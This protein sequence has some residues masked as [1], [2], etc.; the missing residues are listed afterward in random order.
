MKQ[1]TLIGIKLAQ[2]EIIGAYNLHNK[3]ARAQAEARKEG[4]TFISNYYKADFKP[5][6]RQ[7]IDSPSP[8]FDIAAR[9]LLLESESETE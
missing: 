9:I 7:W 4:A 1:K 5:F 3:K 8:L 2:A 6:V